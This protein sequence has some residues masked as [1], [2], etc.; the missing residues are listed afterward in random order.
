MIAD[1]DEEVLI[2]LER[3]LQDQS[4]ETTTAWNTDQALGLLESRSFDL[5][6]ASDHPP[7]LS[8]KRIL[9]A[10]R[11]HQQATPI[12]I[13]ESRETD[14]F[15]EQ[16]FASLGGSAF[17]NKWR[18]REILESVQQYLDPENCQKVKRAVAG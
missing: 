6:L 13:L 16:H 7:E 17:V 2:K 15:A 12:I 18:H 4:H 3:L 1:S 14:A 10:A 9:D 11:T 8:C 5:I